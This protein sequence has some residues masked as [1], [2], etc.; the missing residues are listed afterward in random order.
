MLVYTGTRDT[1][2][3]EAFLAAA[4]VYK[5]I[6]QIND[7]EA[8]RS[9]PLILKD[10]VATWW[11]GVKKDVTTWTDF[12]NR[13]RLAFAPKRPAYQ[14]YQEIIAIKQG[15][16]ELTETF[17]SKKRALFAQL[18][19]SHSETQQLDMLYGQVRYE[20]RVKL[21]RETVKTFEF[22]KA[23]RSVER[24][25][26]EKQA[27]PQTQ[28]TITKGKEALPKKA[29][30]G[31]CRFP[32]HTIDNCRKKAR[33]EG[34]A[35]GSGDTTTTAGR[36]MV[37]TLGTQAPSPSQAKFSCYGCGMPGM[38]RS[39]CPTCNNNK[40]QT[41]NADKEISFCSIDVKIDCRPRPVIGIGVDNIA[42]TAYIDSCAKTSVASYGLYQCL[43][44]LVYRCGE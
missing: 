27:Q 24:L 39:K 33:D 10:E 13:L 31:Y 20:I 28:P 14:I 12:Q 9:V 17:V 1:E 22:L 25:L 21:A 19:E 37:S 41:P 36:L 35:S 26:T 6:E 40:K 44:R 32:G 34:V 16:G 4:T 43:K 29:K 42:G 7:A 11:N 2:A 5:S 23:A 30:C 38:V 15:S 8:L 18:P 3:V